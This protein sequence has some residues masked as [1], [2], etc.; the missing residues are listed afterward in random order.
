MM[1]QVTTLGIRSY[2]HWHK[3]EM[4]KKN[5]K[6]TTLFKLCKILEIS[7]SRLLNKVERL[8]DKKE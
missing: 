2:G 5:I 4:G 7:P 8:K 3:I 6:F 1:C